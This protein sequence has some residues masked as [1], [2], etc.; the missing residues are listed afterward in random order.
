MAKKYRVKRYYGKN[1]MSFRAKPRVLTV[2]F[3]L[4]LFVGLGYLGTIIYRP[5]YDFVMNLSKEP[6]PIAETL[7]EPESGSEPEPEAEREPE[8]PAEPEY[9]P[10][11]A[12]YVPMATGGT[13]ADIDAIISGL[14][15]TGANAVMIDIKNSAG[16]VLFKTKNEMANKWG[17]VSGNAVD[18]RELAGKLEA[19]GLMLAAKMSVFRDP[20]AASAGRLAYAI[21]YQDSEFLW[22][23]AAPENGGRP[24]L[25]PY[26]IPTQEYINSLADEAFDAGVKLLVLEN[27]QFPD[28]SAVYATFGKDAVAMS[29]AEILETTVL[30]LQKKAE[31]KGAR[32]AVTFPVTA[33]TRTEGED[34]RYGGSIL[35]TVGKYLLLDVSP[36]QFANGF[37]QNGL[38]IEN[39]GQ[40]PVGAVKAA[41]DYIKQ[42]V[43]PETEIIP[44]LGG[45][46]D[47]RDALIKELGYDEY[48]VQE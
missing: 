37:S 19:K 40:D 48:F 38:E 15:G 32:V 26:S 14:E 9:E 41:I 35:K 1:G 44:M 6:P 36:S 46:K 13:T 31:E 3:V 4:L 8:P 29:R 21:N 20:R 30:N 45:T 5:V 16:D 28:N 27:V 43:S 25:N 47:E 33:V 22:L 23:D 34:S 17:V 18:L 12:V 42:G 24:W 2:V 7:P 10:L 11:R 39:A